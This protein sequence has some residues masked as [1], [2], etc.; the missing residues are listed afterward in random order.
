MSE[1]AYRV[2][3]RG[4]PLSFVL[5]V[6]VFLA[7]YVSAGPVRAEI[8]EYNLH[9]ALETARAECRK[10]RALSTRIRHAR[11]QVR[12]ARA[13]VERAKEILRK[14][15]EQLRLAIENFRR[16]RPEFQSAAKVCKQAKWSYRTMKRMFL[17]QSGGGSGRRPGGA[18]PRNYPPSPG[19][20]SGTGRPSD[21][22]YDCR[23]MGVCR[24]RPRTAPSP[25]GG[26]GPANAPSGDDCGLLGV[27]APSVRRSR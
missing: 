24:D 2:P 10:A 15:R 13:R 8:T 26:G 19:G 3:R 7:P 27:C 1:R 17:E 23:L 6:A 4:P 22:D 5:I 16:I 12:Q 11:Q 20:A 21:E 9:Q 25:G 14:E 18:P